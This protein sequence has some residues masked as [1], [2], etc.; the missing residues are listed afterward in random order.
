MEQTIEHLDANCNNCKFLVRDLEKFKQSVERH[1]KWQLDH[2]NAIKNSF[3]KKSEEHTKRAN[4]KGQ[5]RERWLRKAKGCLT[6]ANK[7][8]FQFNKSEVTINYGSCS[9]LNKEV[10]FIPNVCQLET[11]HCFVHRKD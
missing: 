6:E 2:F 11:Q 5:D 10:T 9:K 4:G 7:M 8:K 1:H 3:I